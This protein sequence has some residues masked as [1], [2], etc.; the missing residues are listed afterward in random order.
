[1]RVDRATGEVRVDRVTAAIDCGLA[2]N[3]DIVTAQT[4][5]AIMMGLSAAL[6]EEI[7]LR[8]G[9]WSASAFDNYPIF[10]I[11]DAPQ[12][13]VM[14]V[15]NRESSPGGVGEPPLAPAAAAV[16]NAIFDAVGARIRTMP[17]TPARVLAALDSI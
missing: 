1:V 7:T 2:I 15:N 10:T 17:M 8:D 6:R 16:G 12:V 11:A 9:I 5:G 13:D 4:E 3:P 14:V